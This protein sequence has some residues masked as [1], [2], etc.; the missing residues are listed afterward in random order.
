MGIPVP[1]ETALIT[2]ALVAS[3]GR[4]PIVGVIAVAAAGAI[5][6]DNIGFFFIGRKGGRRLLERPGRF[7]KERRRAL[8]IGDPFFAR[9]GAKAVFFGRWITG[10]RT[11]ASW[12]A[13]A[14][15]M[16]WHTFLIW[17]AAGGIAWATTVGLAVYYAGSGAKKVITQVG[18]YALIAV[19]VL[20]VAGIA[21]FLL[22]RRRRRRSASRRSQEAN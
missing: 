4:V 12:L 18:L 16:P 22:V 3:Q 5:I 7:E 11:W 10:L 8:E 14:S 13:G 19:A 20:A 17:N 2:M 21:T 6:G 15:E 9:H 1:G